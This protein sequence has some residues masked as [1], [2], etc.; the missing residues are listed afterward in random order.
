MDQGQWLLPKVNLGS[1]LARHR[2]VGHAVKT[3]IVCQ[4]VGSRLFEKLNEGVVQV[5]VPARDDIDN[6]QADPL[7]QITGAL[8]G[9]CL[10]V[11]TRGLQLPG[12]TNS[13]AATSVGPPSLE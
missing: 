11:L 2:P 8:D 5:G 3:D 7:V 13:T 9:K 1:A 12:L 6:D 10:A 4:A